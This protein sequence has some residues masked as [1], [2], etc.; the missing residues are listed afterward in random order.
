MKRIG[1]RA[2]LTFALLGLALLPLAVATVVL[3]RMNLGRLAESAREYRMAVASEVV[4]TLENR[5]D[6]ALTEMGI[7]SAALAERGV[8]SEDRVRAVRAQLLGSRVLDGIA[9]YAPDGTHVDSIVAGPAAALAARPETLPPDIVRAVAERGAAFGDVVLDDAGHPRLPVAVPAYR[10]GEQ[11]V[12]AYLW[13]AL[14]LEPARLAVAEASARRFLGETDRVFVVDANLRVVLHSDPALLLKPLGERG[15]AFG[16]PED[17]SFLRN[18]QVSYAAS[19]EVGGESLLG[20]LVPVPTARWGLAV[21]QERDEA[22]AAVRSTWMTATVVA[23]A[24]ALLALGIGLALGRRLSRPVLDVAAAAGQVAGGRFDVRVAVRRHDE[25]G[26]MADAFNA[27]ARDLGDYRDRIVEETRI[28]TNL[29]RYLSPDVVEDVVS[30][31]TDLVLGGQRREVSVLFADVA[32]FTPFAEGFPPEV[33]V[34]VLNELFSIATEAV[35]RHGGTVDKFIGDC[36]MA[37]FGAPAVLEDHT[38]RAVRAADEIRRQVAAA[39]ERWRVDPGRDIQLSMGVHTGVVVAGNIGSQRRMEYTVI[40]DAVNVAAR[41]Q[42]VAKGGQ[43][44]VSRD[45]VDRLGGAFLCESGGSV[46]LKGKSN[47]I[48]VFRVIGPAAGPA[49]ETGGASE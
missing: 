39:N 23:V 7:A 4:Q 30:R 46:N 15:R 35:F 13:T 34:G 25:V 22:Y 28:R 41:L 5:L 10:S 21:E 32:S 27:M 20:V 8:P 38:V 12:Y 43:I 19:Y 49:D 44:V 26:Q 42:G 37:V 6:R 29:S 2:R 24:F 33:V 17:G 14:D 3:V 9:V 48:E 18:V 31:K 16:L 1:L 45:V 36:V 47:E 11:S 40:G